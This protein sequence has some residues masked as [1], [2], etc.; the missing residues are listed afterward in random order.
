MVD[1]TVLIRSLLSWDL[2]FFWVNKA[3]LD[4]FVFSFLPTF[5][6]PWLLWCFS[7]QTVGLSR[8]LL[9]LC[10]VSDLKVVLQSR[11]VLQIGDFAI[12]KFHEYEN[13]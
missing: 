11:R 7:M 10:S 2:W 4:V 12:I 8:G 3:P 5:P 13:S 6:P 1:Y 9:S